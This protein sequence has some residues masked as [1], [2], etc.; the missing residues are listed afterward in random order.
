LAGG[1][2]AICD[3]VVD[4][5]YVQR[6]YTSALAAPLT[7]FEAAE[8]WFPIVVRT[9]SSGNIELMVKPTVTMESCLAYLHE[10]RK[11][12][13]HQQLF[14]YGRILDLDKT[15]GDFNLFRGSTIHMITEEYFWYV[16]PPKVTVTASD[17]PLCRLSVF[18]VRLIGGETLTCSPSKFIQVFYVKRKDDASSASASKT[19]SVADY[20]EIPCSIIVNKPEE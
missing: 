4:E 5:V 16:A 18:N 12:P 2:V 13:R 1:N 11:V 17:T 8:G 20:V 10:E 14:H 9:P 15:I 19:S 7:A 3:W 6:T